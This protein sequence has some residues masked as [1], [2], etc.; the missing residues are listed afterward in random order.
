MQRMGS[1][2]GD[3]GMVSL[4]HHNGADEGEA[5]MTI[6][7]SCDGYAEARKSLPPLS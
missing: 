6:T 1:V 2:L 7:T 3:G 5:I 4:H